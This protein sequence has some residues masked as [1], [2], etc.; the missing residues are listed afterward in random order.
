M[1]G[2]KSLPPHHFPGGSPSQLND[3]KEDYHEAWKRWWV[4][5]RLV[6]YHT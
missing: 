6:Q 5:T 2:I 3:R 4:R 1:T